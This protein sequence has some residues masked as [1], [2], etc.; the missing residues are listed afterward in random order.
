MIELLDNFWVLL[1]IKLLIIALVIPAVALGFIFAELKISAHMQSRI[2]PY[3]AGGRWGWAQPLADGLKFMQKEDLIPAD[4]DRPVFRFAP[5]V[6]LMGTLAV[7]VVIPFSP[8]LIVADLDIGVFYALAAASIGAVGVLMAG[9]SSANKYSLMGGMRAAAQLIAYEL[10]LV[11][12]V[13]GVVIQAETMSLPGIVAGV[14]EGRFAPGE[15]IRRDQM[16]T[17]LVRLLD[18]PVTAELV[19]ATGGAQVAVAAVAVIDVGGRN[20]PAGGQFPTGWSEPATDPAE[21]VFRRGTDGARIQ[22]VLPASAEGVLL[23]WRSDAEA[24]V[25]VS[26]DGTPA[27]TLPVAGEWRTGYVP[28]GPPRRLPRLGSEPRW[29]ADRAFPAF[30]AA[31][32]LFVLPARSDIEHWFATTP[33]VRW[34]VNQSPSAS[35]ALTLVGMQGVYGATDGPSVIAATLVCSAPTLILFLLLQRYFVRGLLAG[36]VKG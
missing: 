21:G 4:A 24:T 9:W 25:T 11:L 5:M 3:F 14:G 2:G 36:S 16:A 35:D 32:R 28:V 33:D 1:A 31:R 10:P 8:R 27:I 12:A 13:V 6:V 29:E 15:P 19:L 23:R 17:F 18:P 30:T 20:L 22:V 34:R 26:V 7:F